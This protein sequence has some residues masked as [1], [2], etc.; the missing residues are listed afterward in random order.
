[1]ISVLLF[2]SYIGLAIA[3][4]QAVEVDRTVARNAAVDLAGSHF[5]AGE[6]LAG[7]RV[8]IRIE[9]ATPMFF[10]AETQE[11][12]RIQPSPLTRDQARRATA[13]ALVR[14]GHGP[15]AG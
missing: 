11:L 12:F 8:S 10:A 1:V 15:A 13:A 14:A 6:I 9:E 7:R 3:Q 5:P 4:G 2:S